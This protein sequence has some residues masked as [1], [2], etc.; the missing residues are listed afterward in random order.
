MGSWWSNDLLG[1]SSCHCLN[2]LTIDVGE[3]GGKSNAKL[4]KI[5]LFG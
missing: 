2:F 5:P 4:G 1:S 3:W